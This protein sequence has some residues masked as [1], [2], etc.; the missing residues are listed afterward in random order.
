MTTNEGHMRA[1]QPESGA[2]LRLSGKGR[3]QK[4]VVSSRVSSDEI[5]RQ[6]CAEKTILVLKQVSLGVQVHTMTTGD[7]RQSTALGMRQNQSTSDVHGSEGPDAAAHLE[8]VHPLRQ[9]ECLF[10]TLQRLRAHQ[11]TRGG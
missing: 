4:E 2:W 3:G 6:L 8:V 10:P 7:R 9:L 1:P 11:N 5:Q